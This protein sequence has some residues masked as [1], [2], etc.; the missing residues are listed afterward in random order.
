MGAYC[1]PLEDAK[2]EYT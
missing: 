1:I 2:G